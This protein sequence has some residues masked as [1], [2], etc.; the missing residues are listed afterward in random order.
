MFGALKSPSKH[1][2]NIGALKPQIVRQGGTRTEASKKE[3]PALSG[4]SLAL[5]TINPK[6]FREPHWHPN[7]NELFYLL[8]GKALMTIF[9]PGNS[10]DTFTI[11]PG[12]IVFVPMGFLH[13]I[14]NIGPSPVKIVVCF[15]H[16]QPEDLGISDSVH[17]M[18][19]KILGGT[20]KQTAQFFN[21]VQKNKYD[22]YFGVQEHPTVPTL[23]NATGRYKLNL[24]SINP[25]INSQGG[26]V[27][28]SNSY[29]L[30]PL[31]GL[32]IYSLNLKPNGAREPHWHPDADEL[33]Y[34]VRGHAKITLLSP[35]GHVDT[36]N[37][38]PGD[39]SFMPKGYIHHIETVGNEDAF[40]TIFFNHKIPS[41]I[42]I[43]GC[44]GAY[45]NELL[46]ALFKTPADYFDHLPKYQQDLFVVTG[47]G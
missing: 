44:L 18:P 5:L 26:W 32:A 36:F 35:G 40:F 24:E 27:K 2:Y 8:E 20:F 19:S 9:G 21:T 33:N 31:D 23:A 28:L 16:E 30:P 25:Q 45:P 4:M 34:L 15:N 22:N 38:V 41:D 39:M 43:S 7:A 47:A 10:H 1:L 37:M 46:A 14:E 3:L 12:E 11:E 29:L 13:H 17:V 42:G 6:G